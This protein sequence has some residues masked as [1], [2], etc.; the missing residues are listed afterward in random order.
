MS[1]KTKKILTEII[2]LVVLIAGLF[3]LIR[4]ADVRVTFGWNILA[5]GIVG[6]IVLRF[7]QKWMPF[8]RFYPLRYVLYALGMGLIVFIIAVST[9][10]TLGSYFSWGRI[11]ALTCTGAV[12]GLWIGLVEHLTFAFRQRKNPY[13]GDDQP[14]LSSVAKIMDNYTINNLGRI[15]LLSD[16]LLFIGTDSKKFEIPFSDIASVE[17]VIRL[18]S[19][20]L[21]ELNLK[22]AEAVSIRLSMPYIWKRKIQEALRCQP[23]PVL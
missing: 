10:F 18:L 7:F 6:G 12:I 2:R 4:I 17:V 19:R 9:R 16:H 3:L 8:D 14:V 5:G 20:S 23:N 13:T 15:L 11:M 1:K 21:L 22:D